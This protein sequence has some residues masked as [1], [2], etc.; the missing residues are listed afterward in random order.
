MVRTHKHNLRRFWRLIVKKKIILMSLAGALVA[1]AIVGGT[2]AGFNTQSKTVGV[3]DI[4]LKAISI[5]LNENSVAKGSETTEKI[6]PGKDVPYSFNVTNDISDGYTFY[7]RVA[8]DMK[9]KLA[10]KNIKA[11]GD[12]LDEGDKVKLVVRNGSDDIELT[13]GTKVN[14]W[15]VW[16]A[17]D[18]QVIMYYTKPLKSGET[19]GDFVNLIRFDKTMGNKYTDATVDLSVET[20]CVQDIAADA[21]IP[22]EWGVYPTFDEA[23]NIVSIEE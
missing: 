9:L 13:K 4:N 11:Y 7:A 3:S 12:A 18:E 22:A 6:L 10:E 8:I 14:D 2:L 20:D 17:D 16:Y 23:G 15:I 19:S 21:A 1:T 5:R